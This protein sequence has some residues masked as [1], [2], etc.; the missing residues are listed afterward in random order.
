MIKSF[1]NIHDIK[2]EYVL[3]SQINILLLTFIWIITFDIF[4]ALQAA[5]DSMNNGLSSYVDRS[6]ALRVMSLLTV[7]WVLPFDIVYNW[8]IR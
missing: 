4:L 6:R 2:F 8:G 7:P 3:L 1:K 5:C